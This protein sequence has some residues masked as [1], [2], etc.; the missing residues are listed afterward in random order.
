[1][2]IFNSLLKP[3]FIVLSIFTVS[4]VF[5]Q[6]GT[7]VYGDYGAVAKKPVNSGFSWDKVTIGGSLGAS[8]GSNQTYLEIAPQLS[9]FLTENIL[10][11][12]GGNYIYFE[13]KQY[14]ISTSL[15]GAR[16]FSQYVFNE[17][18]ILAH[19]EG[20]LINI[21]LFGSSFNS[22][23]RINIYNFY[24]GGGLKQALG[25]TS[26]IYV[27]ALYN[28]NETEESRLILPNPNIRIGIA[29]GL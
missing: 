8:F 24:V 15:Y 3:I 12:V 20:E 17:L 27:L 23:D 29:V 9:Y 13:D 5:S 14:N 19:I 1:M 2:N 11:G 4:C 18:P 16:I 21:E 6:D 25:G 22:S 26:F 7:Y 28:L 10:L